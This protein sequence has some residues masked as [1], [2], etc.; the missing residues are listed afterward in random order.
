VSRVAR[1]KIDMRLDA[2]GMLDGC[3]VTIDRD[4][5]LFSVRPKRRRKLYTLPLYTVA[6][7]VAHRIELNEAAAKRAAKKAR[8]KGKRS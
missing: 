5:G 7:M 3:T 4:A 6:G 8:R 2:A 1:F